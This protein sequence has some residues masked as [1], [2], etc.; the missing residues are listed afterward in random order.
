MSPDSQETADLVTFAKTVLNGKA[1]FL[2]L[3]DLCFGLNLAT[4]FYLHTD[5]LA[6]LIQK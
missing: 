1:Y 6:K 2:C 5:N 4:G 3:P